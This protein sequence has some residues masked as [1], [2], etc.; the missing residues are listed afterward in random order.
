[1]ANK[2]RAQGK[3]KEEYATF[4][5]LV[6]R[7]GVWNLSP[8]TFG[9]QYGVPRI[10]VQS[11]KTEYTDAFTLEKLRKFAKPMAQNSITAMQ[12]LSKNILSTDPKIAI[13]ASEKYI[14]SIEKFTHGMERLGFKI[15]EYDMAPEIH[16][17][18]EGPIIGRLDQETQNK[19]LKAIMPPEPVV[20][21]AKTPKKAT[22]RRV[23][24]KKKV[25]IRK[26]QPK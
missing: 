1:M 21:E 6:E 14:S 18:S 17:H 19:L 12:T 4:L 22:K 15:A 13:A 25:I 24:T 10:T 2:K 8:T 11:W 7:M 26:K 16:L 5:E 9:E 23:V 3:Y 20:I